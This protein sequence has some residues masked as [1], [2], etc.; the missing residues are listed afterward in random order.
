MSYVGTKSKLCH[1]IAFDECRQAT[2]S[3]ARQRHWVLFYAVMDLTIMCLG[4]HKKFYANCYY[5]LF[6]LRNHYLMRSYAL[7]L[8]LFLF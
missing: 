8:S 2:V 6:H 4:A 3:G 1:S 7:N 5:V